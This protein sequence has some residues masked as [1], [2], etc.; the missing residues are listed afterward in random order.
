MDFWEDVYK[1]VSDAAEFTA[2]ETGKYTEIAKAK[3]NLMR[4]KSRLEDAYRNLG[5]VYYTQLKTSEIDEKKITSAYDKVEKSIV[6]IDRINQEINV[7][8]NT[9]TCES[10]G[11]KIDKDNAFCPKCGHKINSDEE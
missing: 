7:L 10:C 11:Q 4:E 8:K 9:V 1:K 5:E 2:K 6:E 3:F